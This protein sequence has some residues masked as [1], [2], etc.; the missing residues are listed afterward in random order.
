MTTATNE[1]NNHTE[2]SNANLIKIQQKPNEPIIH[3][4]NI[5]KEE[6]NVYNK[7]GISDMIMSNIPLVKE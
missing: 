6:R 1:N 4:F 3:S 5:T 2:P 7:I